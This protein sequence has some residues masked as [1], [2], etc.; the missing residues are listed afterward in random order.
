MTYAHSKEDILKE[1][2]SWAK[3]QYAAATWKARCSSE[4]SAQNEFMQQYSRQLLWC[5][6]WVRD[7]HPCS[8]FG[9]VSWVVSR[10]RQFL[11]RHKPSLCRRDV[12]CCVDSG[13]D[14]HEKNASRT[15]NRTY[16]INKEQCFCEVW[17]I[18]AKTMQPGSETIR[19]QPDFTRR[20][21]KSKGI[22]TSPCRISQIL[23]NKEVPCPDRGCGSKTP[24][25]PAETTK[26]VHICMENILHCCQWVHDSIQIQE[27]LKVHVCFCH[28]KCSRSCWCLCV[29]LLDQQTALFLLSTLFS[30]Y[31]WTWKTFKV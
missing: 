29:F 31:L 15:S 16:D 3:M 17:S 21:S 28:L 2:R 12:Y 25:L 7:E 18:D 13:T 23:R 1:P 5:C 24:E 27:I 8:W 30:C 4:Q 19:G 11:S 10:K 14:R 26:G 22:V 6:L 9:D 20:D